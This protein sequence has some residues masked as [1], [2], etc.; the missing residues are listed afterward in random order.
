M[1]NCRKYS[2]MSVIPG[3]AGYGWML[4]DISAND[5]RFG[6][7]LGSNLIQRVPEVPEP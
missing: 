2:A 1:P 6:T 5:S 3:Y 7:K 4:A